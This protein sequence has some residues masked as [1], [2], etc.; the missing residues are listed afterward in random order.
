MWAAPSGVGENISSCQALVALFAEGTKSDMNESSQLMEEGIGP[1]EE[2]G[3]ALQWI[4]TTGHP[5]HKVPTYFF[6]MIDPLTKVEFGTINLR[7][8]RSV[9][10]ERYAGHIGY[11]VVPEHRGHHYAAR[12]TKLLMPLAR[13]LGFHVLSITCDPENMASRRS[14]EVAGAILQEIVDVPVT[15]TIYRH[16]HPKKCRYKLSL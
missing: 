11:S 5:V 13:S 7:V 2:E 6:R 8:G 12:A 15:C 4:E 1:L 14:C 10:I 9:H 3:L 16:G